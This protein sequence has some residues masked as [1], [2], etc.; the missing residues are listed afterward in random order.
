MIL[1]GKAGILPV[2]EKTMGMRRMKQLRRHAGVRE[3]IVPFD[4]EA[5]LTIPAN[6]K[7][8]ENVLGRLSLGTKED[9]TNANRA[10]QEAG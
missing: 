8:A 6:K 10:D 4:I 2:D 5:R 7:Q 1:Y 3:K 9:A